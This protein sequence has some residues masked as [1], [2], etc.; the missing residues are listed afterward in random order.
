MMMRGQGSSEYLIVL[1]VVLVV[2]LV[3]IVLVG[4]FPAMGGDAR[5]AES[6]QYWIGSAKP[7]SITEQ[8]QINDTV[9]IT[10]LN[11]ESTRFVLR[12]ITLTTGNR[13][14]SPLDMP[15]DGFTMGGGVRKTITISNMTR[16]NETSYDEYEYDVHITYDTSDIAGKSEYGSKPIIGKCVVP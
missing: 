4:G 1:A 2:S 9:F 3:T 7:F 11:T 5:K 16:C 14:F 15:T 13:T 8:T 12:N 6:S 10:L